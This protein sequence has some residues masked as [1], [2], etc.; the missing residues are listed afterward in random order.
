MPLR[1]ASLDV[2]GVLNSTTW[3]R[4][5][6]PWTFTEIQA[7]ARSGPEMV[8]QPHLLEKKHLLFSLRNVNPAAVALLNRVI[9]R[10]GAKVVISSSW[11]HAFTIEGFRWLFGEKGF[12]GEVIGCT[13]LEERLT[14]GAEIWAWLQE[15]QVEF[16]P[17]E[18]ERRRPEHYQALSSQVRAFRKEV[19]GTEKMGAM[20]TPEEKVQVTQR[21][22]EAQEKLKKELG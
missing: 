10:T 4:P 12:R 17:Q 15:H 21:I 16:P 6:G 14:R 11:R 9:E 1:V 22:Q 20:L 19:R 5:S 2:D 13:T 7:L 3:K 8:R 18:L